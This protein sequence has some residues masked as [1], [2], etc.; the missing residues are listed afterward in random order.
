MRA[1]LI[2]RT[3]DCAA[4]YAGRRQMV[5]AKEDEMA[6]QV[7]PVPEGYHTVTPYLYIRGATQAIDFYKRAFGAEERY[8]MP[9]PDGRIGHAEL[10]LGDSIIMLADE[11][12]EHGIKSPHSLSG[13]SV[14]LA[15]YV[16]DAD[17]AFNRAVDAGA[18]VL[19]PLKDQF[20]GDRSGKVADPYGH[21][22]SL[23][24]H[25]EDVSPEE[26]SKRMQAEFGAMA[27][28]QS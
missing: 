26:M 5:T 2:S 11:M 23:M 18:T 13:T 10:T 16:E 22:W 28:T 24:T 3:T 12:P 1:I 9:G 20:Y 15:V 19:Q 21:Q 7:R 25:V 27:G 4:S 6:N 14:S 17:A 8:R